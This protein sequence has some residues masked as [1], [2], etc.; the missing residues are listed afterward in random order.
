MRTAGDVMSRTLFLIASSASV[1][2]ASLR[3]EQNHLHS[4]LVERAD[5]LDAYGIVTSTD[6]IH[7]VLAKGKDP[8]RVA[9]REVMSKPII[10]IPPDC[11]LFDVAQLMARN[12]INHLPVFDGRQVIGMVSSTD[13][14]K[15]NKD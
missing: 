12:H 5:S 15:A 3:M 14:F 7:K 9:V 1:S 11:R 4:L 2:D 6:I 10:T 13:I 8:G